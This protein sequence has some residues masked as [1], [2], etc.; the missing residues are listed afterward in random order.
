MTTRTALSVAATTSSLK[1]R[2][3]ETA[4]TTAE[5]P[6][7]EAPIEWLPTQAATHG[8]RRFPT[9]SRP[10]DLRRTERQI[11]LHHWECTVTDLDDGSFSATLRSLRDT[12]ESE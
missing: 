8:L 1:E 10:V 5:V 6:Q 4:P 2:T 11:V 9:M 3:C 7:V 12:S